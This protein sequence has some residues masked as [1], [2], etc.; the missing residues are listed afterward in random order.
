EQPNDI[1]FIDASKGFEKAKTQNFLRTEHI[2]R[3]VNTYRERQEIP[4]FSKKST[5]KEVAENDYNLNIPRYVDTFKADDQLDIN[6]IALELQTLE[7]DM[8]TTDTELATFCTALGI[9]TPFSL[10]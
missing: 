3:I 6:A 4:K 1:L 7:L 9:E 8:K 2:D 10:A 5:L